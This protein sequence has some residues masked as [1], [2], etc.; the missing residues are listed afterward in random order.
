MHFLKLY[1]GNAWTKRLYRRSGVFLFYRTRKRATFVSGWASKGVGQFSLLI[2][3]YKSNNNCGQ[4]M[5]T[6][7]GKNQVGQF[8][9]REK[10]K[11]SQ[12]S[13]G[14]SPHRVT[15]FCV[16]D[17]ERVTIFRPLLCGGEIVVTLFCIPH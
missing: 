6:Y 16:R 11:L 5:Y 8:F 4:N 12:L 14:A 10:T 1:A 3:K 2:K 7:V 17:K 13:A 15:I 9:A